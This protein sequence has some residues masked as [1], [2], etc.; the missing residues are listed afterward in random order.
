MALSI[1]GAD[2]T[3]RRRLTVTT[4]TPMVMVIIMAINNFAGAIVVGVDA[5]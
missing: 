3:I 1:I 2:F 4:E 5:M